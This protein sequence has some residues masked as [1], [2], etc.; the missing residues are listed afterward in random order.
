MHIKEIFGKKIVC[1]HIFAVSE[2]TAGS[3][4]LSAGGVIAVIED[5]SRGYIC[6]HTDNE[7]H[8]IVEAES[9]IFQSKYSKIL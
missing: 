9:L 2:I 1:N 6:Y 8:K 7:P 3:S 4:W 5:T